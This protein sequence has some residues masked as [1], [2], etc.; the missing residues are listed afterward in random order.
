MLE[1][2]NIDVE[3]FTDDALEDWMSRAKANGDSE[4]AAALGQAVR[5]RP[6]SNAVGIAVTTLGFMFLA[7]FVLFIAAVIAV[8]GEL[9]NSELAVGLLFFAGVLGL[10]G[11]LLVKWGVGKLWRDSGENLP[12]RWGRFA[13]MMGWVI[14]ASAGLLALLVGVFDVSLSMASLILTAIPITSVALARDWL[15]R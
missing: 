9:D 11:T 8:R 6:K 15:R 1:G 7:T 3:G 10:P 14:T 12:P 4:L 5:G 2:R 13:L